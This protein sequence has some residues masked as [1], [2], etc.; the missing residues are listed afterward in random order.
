MGEEKNQKI[1]KQAAKIKIWEVAPSH[2][3][4][5][6]YLVEWH[7][8]GM[9]LAWAWHSKRMMTKH[10]GRIFTTNYLVAILYIIW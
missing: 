2:A 9:G 1:V 10:R 7:R 4:I 8:L 3:K 6:Y 5:N